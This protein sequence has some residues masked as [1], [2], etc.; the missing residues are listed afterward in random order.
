MR[1]KTILFFPACMVMAF[2][3]LQLACKKVDSSYY[4]YENEIKQFDGNAL[5]Y[6]ESEPGKYDS[7]LVVMNRLP[8]L[9]DS[10]EKQ[11]LTVFALSNK[12]FE[13]A[14][15]NL[16]KVRKTENKTPLYLK[17][18]D[19]NQLD[20]LISR[21]LIRGKKTTK[22]FQDFVDGVLVQSISHNYTMHILYNKAN[23]SGFVGGGPQI[24]TLSD[25]KGS[26]FV[27]FWER[28]PTNAVNIKANNAI[29]NIIAPDH[30]FGF[31]DFIK[32]VNN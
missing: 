15:N 3:F 31:N 23:A 32:R 24:L 14:L 11:E 1:N 16:N 17:D 21:Y 2:I 25:P 8:A 10:L 12:S 9:R 6:L 29:I 4:K 30:N 22:D 20:T 27:K 13:L 18:V 28:T 19:V 26:I 7:M 5:K